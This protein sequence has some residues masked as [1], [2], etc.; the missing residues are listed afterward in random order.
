MYDTLKS[1]RKKLVKRDND[2]CCCI[3]LEPFAPSATLGVARSCGHHFHFDCINEWMKTKSTCPTCREP[4]TLT[5]GGLRAITYWDLK[6][7]MFAS[8]GKP[9]NRMCSIQSLM[10]DENGTPNQ[11]ILENHFRAQKKKKKSGL[12]S[13]SATKR[14]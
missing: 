4:I 3:C 7:M 13:R 12:C 8:I 1:I 10:D 9:V 14:K 6:K 2:I 11:D 5:G